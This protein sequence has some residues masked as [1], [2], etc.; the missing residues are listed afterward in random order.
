MSS[1]AKQQER[2][3]LNTKW[4]VMLSMLAGVGLQHI[5]VSKWY[6]AVVKTAE[7]IGAALHG[8]ASLFLTA[9]ESMSG[10][11]LVMCFISLLLVV[12][13][14]WLGFVRLIK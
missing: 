1:E 13:V 10:F 14:L 9:F 4:T 5:E 2:P 12:G 6:L 11:Q 3:P 7:G 8:I